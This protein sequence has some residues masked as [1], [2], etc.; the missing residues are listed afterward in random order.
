MPPPPP[1]SQMRQPEY[2]PHKTSGFGLPNVPARGGAYRYRL[3]V[4]GV[5]VCGITAFVTVRYLRKVSRDR[6][7]K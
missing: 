4:I 7:G 1:A 5:V 6:D 3:M 2:M